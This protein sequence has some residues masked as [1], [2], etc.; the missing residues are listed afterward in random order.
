MRIGARDRLARFLDPDSGVELAVGIEPEDPLKFR[1]TQALQ[2]RL[3]A[4]QKATGEKDA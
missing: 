3:T 1:D 4:A 2:D